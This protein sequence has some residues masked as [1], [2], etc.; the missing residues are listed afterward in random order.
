MEHKGTSFVNSCVKVPVD[1][2][3]RQPTPSYERPKLLIHSDKTAASTNDFETTRSSN[4]SLSCDAL[5][6]TSECSTSLEDFST[7]LKSIPDYNQL[8]H[9]S[10]EQFK[11]KLDYLKRKRKMLSMNL[12]N[13]IINGS[14]KVS[15]ASSPCNEKTTLSNNESKSSEELNL[16]G[17]KCNFQESRLMSPLI[18]SDKFYEFTAEDQETNRYS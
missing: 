2:Y 17:K 15:V 4:L 16:K 10:N 5:T 8:H 12:S 13:C 14:D 18:F 9:L 6:K 11:Q 3:S 7:F 1:P